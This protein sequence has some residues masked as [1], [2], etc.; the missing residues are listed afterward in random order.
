MVI[1]T[2]SR[3]SGGPK[4][5]EGKLVSSRNALKFGAYSKQ[6]V[7]PGENPE[8]LHEL[9]DLFIADFSPKGVT[10]LSLVNELA[11]LT[12]KK[13][14]LERIENNYLVG[15]LNATETATDFFEAGFPPRSGVDWL[16]NDLSMLTADLVERHVQELAL[17]KSIRDTCASEISRDCKRKAFGF[18]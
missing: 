1:P 12:W 4:S 5:P 17:A 8:D 9:E 14:R 7:L 16:L 3:K 11:I 18:L 13:L 15:L 2:K 10:E 6:A